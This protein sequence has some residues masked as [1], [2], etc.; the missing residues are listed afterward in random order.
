LRNAVYRNG[1]IWTCHTVYVPEAAPTRAVAQWWQAKVSTLTVSQ[2]GRVEDKKNNDKM[3][4]YPSVAVNKHND[5]LMG[6]T[7]FQSTKYASAAY[8]YRN[9]TD[10][11]NKLR[12]STIYKKGKATYFAGGSSGV[13]YNWGTYSATC[14]DTDSSFWTIQ[15][16]AESPAD[17]WGTWWAHVDDVTFAAKVSPAPM[18]VIDNK[19]ALSVSPNPANNFATLIWNEEKSANVKIQVSDNRGNVLVTKSF[20]AQHGNNKLTINV[21]NLISGLYSVVISNGVDTKKTQLVIE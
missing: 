6:Y 11:P 20:N 10:A 1:Q 2:F 7:Q 12:K 4:G 18:Q 3:Y 17:T 19:S 5:M 16:Y 13:T 14:V 8:S 15:E 21:A 9:A